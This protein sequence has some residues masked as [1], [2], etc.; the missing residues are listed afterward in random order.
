MEKLAVLFASLP[1]SEAL[2]A[3]LADPEQLRNHR[4]YLELPQGLS[5][6]FAEV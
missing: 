6:I 2:R 5:V 3:R 4:F 1:V